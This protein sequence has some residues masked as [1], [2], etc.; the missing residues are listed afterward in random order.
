LTC[1]NNSSLGDINDDAFINVIDVINL[2]NI[3]LNNQEYLDSGD[4][5]FDGNL[6]IV[7]V[8]S[9]VNLI[10]VENPENRDTWTII[11][12]DILTPKC[13]QC[14]YEGSFYAETSNLILTNDIAYSQ[15]INRQPYNN[16][17]LNN[18]LD[19]LSDD[20]GMYG[21]LTSF[22]WEKINI[23]NENHFY[24]EHPYYGEIMPLGGPFL[25]NGELDFIE[26][27]IWAG[28]PDTG[29]VAD[30]LILNDI[31]EYEAP[32]FTPLDIPETGVQY[33]IGPFDVYPNSEREFLYYVPPFADEY[34]IKKVE[35][36]MAPGSHHFIS[37]IF[38]DNYFS[39]EPEPYTYRDI[40]APYIDEFLESGNPNPEW[41]N[42][43]MTLQ[44][45]TFVTGTQWPSW[46]YSM[47]DGVALKVDSDFG[48]DLNPHYFNYTDQT[49]QGEVY[50]NLHT[51]PEE[52]VEHIGGIMQLGNNEI[53]LP[54][55]QETVLTEVFS[56][57][58]IVNSININPPSNTSSLNIFQLFTH[59]HQ[60]MTRF[61][62]LLLHPNGEEELIYTALDYEHPPVLSF[63]PPLVLTAGQGLISRATYYNNT[64]NYVNFGLLSTDEM[65]IVFGLVY[66]E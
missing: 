59:A 46:S 48:L 56:T 8:V 28:A 52:E 34:Y 10:L 37:Y 55:N 63:D 41:I 65:K 17:A 3:I 54:P 40:H 5:N 66:Y 25:T 19:L 18:G 21:L 20:G 32:E 29:I 61:D 13:A 2:V 11:S 64:D 14:H 30:P 36:A 45:H 31:S 44:E 58:D 57:Q 62:V 35:M 1:F 7:D 39:S 6:D 53:N 33:H 24:S 16:S 47:P 27:W 38:S 43:V 15:L 50:F 42:N 23:N 12:N 60:L 51:I 49:L 22:F 26:D 4:L 9:L